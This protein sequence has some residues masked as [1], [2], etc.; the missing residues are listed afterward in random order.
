MKIS[1]P[2][3][4]IRKIAPAAARNKNLPSRLPIVLQQG[5]PPPALSC[6]DRTHQP[7]SSRAQNNHIELA[8]IGGHRL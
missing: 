6:D 4:E 7:G 1:R 5:N 2:A 3:A 8:Q